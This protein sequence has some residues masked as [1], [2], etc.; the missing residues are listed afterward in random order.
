VRL[1][2]QPILSSFS[3]WLFGLSITLAKNMV[4]AKNQVQMAST[5]GQRKPSYILT[6]IIWLFTA[7]RK[8]R[9]AGLIFLLCAFLI[10]FYFILFDQQSYIA[11]LEN[12]SPDNNIS[13]IISVFF[14]VQA[15]IISLLLIW[16]LIT[17][18]S[19]IDYL[20][21][22]STTT[23]Q[24]DWR[25]G[26]L[27]YIVACFSWLLI[28][29]LP[30][31]FFDFKTIKIF[32]REDSFFECAG[33]LWLF[34]TSMSFFYLFY[35]EKR[36]Q[37]IL[38]LKTSRNI[39]F[40]LL[41]L[42]FFLGAGEEISWGQR[43]LK[44]NTPEIASSNI[45]KEFNLH[46][47]PLFDTRSSVGEMKD[48]R[49]KR[50]GKTGVSQQ[51]SAASLF[52]YFWF[53]YCVCIPVLRVSSKRIHKWLDQINFP[54]VPIWIGAFFIINFFM[55]YK[56]LPHLVSYPI[57]WPAF[58]IEEAA[59]CFFFFILALYFINSPNHRYDRHKLR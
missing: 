29:Y 33:F 15:F 59:N 42:L 45:Q 18:Q 38:G 13:D 16:L 50:K 40:L 57:V 43:I 8:M 14:R 17:N 51:L 2:R 19:S 23:R 53:F 27:P 5:T 52:A 1:E 28:S 21:E 55:Y 48:G 39:F 31:L 24:L 46:N 37:K 58:E 25:Q 54:V 32:A 34:L 26:K 36:D 30:F 11:L 20:N 41:G 56:I 10:N 9:L 6:C 44:F 12:Y 4:K 47:L 7:V 49:F 3:F 22:T 35:R